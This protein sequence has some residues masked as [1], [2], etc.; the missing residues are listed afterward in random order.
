M[1]MSSIVYSP[2]RIGPG[3][4]VILVKCATDGQFSRR[5]S[6]WSARNTSLDHGARL[7]GPVSG[8]RTPTPIRVVPIVSRS[9]SICPFMPLRTP[10]TEMTDATP[11]MMPV[12]VRIDL[13]TLARI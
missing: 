4:P 5:W 6:N 9:E 13:T 11:M 8:R 1:L 3:I 7:I 2:L 12:V 10:M